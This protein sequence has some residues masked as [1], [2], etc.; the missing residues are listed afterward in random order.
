MKLGTKLTVYISLIIIIVL[1]G[2]GYLRTL[3]RR[4]ILVRKMKGEVRS[5]GRTLKISLEKISLPGNREPVQDL[6][7]AVVDYERTLGVIIYP[8]GRDLIF[9][10]HS[11]VGGIEPFLELIKRSI[12]ED[13]SQEAFR[14]L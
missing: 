12:K 6:I 2:Y 3:S 14:N 4:D 7:D 5:I 8:Q 13:R 1:S 9:R 10:S 11:L